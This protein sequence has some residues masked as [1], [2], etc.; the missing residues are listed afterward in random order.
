MEARGESQHRTQVNPR[1]AGLPGQACLP[2]RRPISNRGR[3]V[4]GAAA[5]RSHS[6]LPQE[7]SFGPETVEPKKAFDAGSMP[8]EKS[9]RLVVAMKPVKAGRAKGAMGF[10]V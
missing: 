7:I 9:D 10:E 5:A 1:K 4:L 6:S 2:T 3:T 8:E